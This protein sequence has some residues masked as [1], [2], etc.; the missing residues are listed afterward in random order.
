MKLETERIIYLNMP[1]CN[2]VLG[3]KHNKAATIAPPAKMAFHWRADSGPIMF[4]T[5]L[6]HNVRLCVYLSLPFCYICCVMKIKRS[7]KHFFCV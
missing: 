4:A 6:P 1:L 3:S 5:G 7:Q 2:Y